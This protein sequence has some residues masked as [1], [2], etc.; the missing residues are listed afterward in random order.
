MVLLKLMAVKG[1]IERIFHK[2]TEGGF[3]VVFPDFDNGATQGE[4]LEEAMEMA[5]DYIG[6]YLYDDF[7]NK[8]ELPKASNIDD[9]EIKIGNDEKEFYI[10]NQSFKS[11][12]SLDMQKYVKESKNQIVRKNVSIPSW[13]NEMAKKNNINFS[14]TL[15]KALKQELGI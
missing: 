13:L 15:Q 11:Y 12:V 6:T 5:Q 10:P 1:L 14:N 7:I 2:A 3:I 8:N 9:L 4:T